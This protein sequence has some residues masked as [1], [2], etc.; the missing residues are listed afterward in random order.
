VTQKSVRHSPTSPDRSGFHQTFCTFTDLGATQQLAH[1]EAPAVDD[2]QPNG[3][4]EVVEVRRQ[5]AAAADHALPDAQRGA[6]LAVYQRDGEPARKPGN[7]ITMT[8]DDAHAAFAHH[9]QPST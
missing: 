2:G 6:H 7:G 1:R 3:F 4:V 9:R 8:D 5:A